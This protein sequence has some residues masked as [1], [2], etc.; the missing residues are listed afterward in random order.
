MKIVTIF[1]LFFLVGCSS[2]PKPPE[3]TGKWQNINIM[4]KR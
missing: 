3:P 2:V 4:D 1:L